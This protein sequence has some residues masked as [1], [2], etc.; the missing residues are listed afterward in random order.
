MY[1]V[2]LDNN[3]T[4]LKEIRFQ[5]I[6]IVSFYSDNAV[7]NLQVHGDTQEIIETKQRQTVYK[8]HQFKRGA[9]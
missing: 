3:I 8:V 1:T 2:S 4:R 5:I 6:V 9:D 7:Y